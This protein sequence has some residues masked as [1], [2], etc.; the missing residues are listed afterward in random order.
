MH[1]KVNSKI[2]DIDDKVKKNEQ[3]IQDL[4]RV[5]NRSSNTPSGSAMQ[6]GSR[7]KPL[8]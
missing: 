7:P 5:T 6:N 1:Q 4:M 2:E 3:E 8:P